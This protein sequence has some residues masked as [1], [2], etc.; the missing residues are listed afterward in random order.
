ML[1]T[2]NYLFP[3][4]TYGHIM[5]SENQN[6]IQSLWIMTRRLLRLY[7]DSAR[8]A[9]AEKMTRLMS[10]IAMFFIGLILSVCVLIFI[11]LGVGRILTEHMADY[12]SFLIMG[13][14][15]LL[16]IAVMIIFRKPL[17]VNPLARF[18]SSL[19]VAPPKSTGQDD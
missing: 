11:T 6:I 3:I 19:I 8:M 13:G 9:L 16:L 5:N 2:I 15:Y 18:L 7:C 10:V 1:L 12:W 17:L 4:G 14:F